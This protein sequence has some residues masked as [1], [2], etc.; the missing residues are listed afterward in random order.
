ML[1]KLVSPPISNIHSLLADLE[2]ARYIG[3]TA[4]TSGYSRKIWRQRRC[5]TFRLGLT[6][7]RILSSAV[8]TN[9]YGAG[10]SPKSRRQ[11]PTPQPKLCP[12]P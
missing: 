8:R 11:S 2:A 6:F 9:P 1:A 3:Q 7:N 10:A 5:T 12:R 4:K